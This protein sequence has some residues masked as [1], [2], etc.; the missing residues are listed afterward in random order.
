[1]RG[2]ALG[3]S[4]RPHPF[5]TPTVKGGA[6]IPFQPSAADLPRSSLPFGFV[7]STRPKP[8][9]RLGFV[10]SNHRNPQTLASLRKTAVFGNAGFAK[11]AFSSPFA[12]GCAKMGHGFF[13][14]F[15]KSVRTPLMVSNKVQTQLRQIVPVCCSLCPRLVA[16]REEIGRV[17]RRAYLDQEYWSKPVPG[18]GDTSARV[19]VV[20]LRPEHMALT[21]QAAF[22]PAIVQASSCIGPCMKQDLR[23]NPPAW[24]AMTGSDLRDAYHYVTGQMRAAGQQADSRRDSHLPVVYGTR[25]GGL[26][27]RQAC[28]SAGRNRAA[29]VSFDFA[30]S[31]GRSGRGLDLSSDMELSLR[32]MKAARWFWRATTRANKIPRP[33]A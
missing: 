26:E 11:N 23:I 16:H 22:S 29:S 6:S 4:A 14:E 13:R 8:R 10:F 1:M 33:D 24:D 31:A 28:G 21:G 30:G 18:F 19:L 25:T 32:L 20:G 12:L 9:T 27:E 15:W 3:P 5:R 17:K 2:R 7:F